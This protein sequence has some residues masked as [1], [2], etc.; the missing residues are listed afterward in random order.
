M[1]GVEWT[2]ADLTLPLLSLI[3]L[4][5]FLRDVGLCINFED[6]ESGQQQEEE[7]TLIRSR[8]RTP[9]RLRLRGV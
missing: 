1:R 6:E 7:G 5:S 3:I 2:V 8:L 9:R 4:P